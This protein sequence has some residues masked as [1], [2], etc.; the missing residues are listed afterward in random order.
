MPCK[1]LDMV[2]L[3]KVDEVA[4]ILRIS[5]SAC[6][7]LVASQQIQAHKIGG[8]IRVCEEDLLSY[9]AGTRITSPQTSVR[10]TRRRRNRSVKH[11]DADRLLAAWK[12]QGVD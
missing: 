12:K 9:I 1:E 7:G 6:Y 3:L 2:K 4:A 8:S 5:R 10:P 11:L